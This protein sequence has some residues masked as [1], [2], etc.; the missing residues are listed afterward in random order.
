[1]EYRKVNRPAEYR[2]DG[3]QAE[4]V[5][6]AAVYYNPDDPGS[7]YRLW[8][9]AVERIL[10]G[11]FDQAIKE[12][13]VRCLWNHDPAKPLARTKS[14]TLE[15]RAT[16]EGLEYRARLGDTSTARDVREH[17]KRGDVDESS[18][19]FTVRPGGDQWDREGDLM[20]RTLSDLRLYDVSPVSYGAYSST[21]VAARF[22]LTEARESLVAASQPEP[23]DGCDDLVQLRARLAELGV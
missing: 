12:D 8:D 21:T 23:A 15:L 5:G 9:G 2:E 16:A 6:M 7:E 1:M 22:N 13:D 19:A 14:G 18:F 3:D 20:V 11:A 17:V 4:L 10:P